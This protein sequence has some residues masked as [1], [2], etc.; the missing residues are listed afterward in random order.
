LCKVFLVLAREGIAI[1]IKNPM[2]VGGKHKDGSVDKVQAQ[3]HEFD[4]HN[5][6]KGGKV[7]TGSKFVPPT[8][9]H[10]HTHT[11][12]QTTTHTPVTSHM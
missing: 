3:Q 11:H 9:T 1:V 6:C 2:G 12:T 7:R 10:T 5:P 4:P 8:H